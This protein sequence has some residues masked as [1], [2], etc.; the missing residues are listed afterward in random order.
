M[1]NSDYDNQVNEAR[2][3]HARIAAQI[4]TPIIIS[5]PA[6]KIHQQLKF[7]QQTDEELKVQ[8]T[9]LEEYRDLRSYHIS[10]AAMVAAARDFYR[11]GIPYL[12][13]REK[14]VD[15]IIYEQAWAREGNFSLIKDFL[16]KGLVPSDTFDTS[17]VE[18]SPHH[19]IMERARRDGYNIPDKF[20]EP[21][22]IR[23][24]KRNALYAANDLQ[25]S[26]IQFVEES[27]KHQRITSVK[28]GFL[29]PDPD[30]E[31]RVPIVLDQLWI[32]Q[33]ENARL[34][35]LGVEIVS[36]F[37][38]TRHKETQ[39]LVRTEKLARQGIEMYRVSGAWC[40]IDSWRAMSEL[41][42]EADIFP[43]ARNFYGYPELKDI[44]DY[45]CSHCQQPMIRFDEYWVEKCYGKWV[46]GEFEEFYPVRFVH[47]KCAEEISNSHL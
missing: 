11:Y 21:K 3:L 6:A 17:G 32:V 16:E 26:Q 44:R 12:D 22:A 42:Y 8:N 19:L 43:K 25:S 18:P 13:A 45:V 39:A 31:W 47:P 36:S 35:F 37:D 15:S 1:S 33:E 20:L 23:D 24:D 2:S 27:R 30:D 28:S 4:D 46:D 29:I 5:K 14:T 41:M 10:K 34:R 40:L 7:R 9:E 38:Q